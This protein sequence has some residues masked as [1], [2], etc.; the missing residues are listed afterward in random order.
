MVFPRALTILHLTYHFCSCSLNKIDH[1]HI[2]ISQPIKTGN[3]MDNK[4]KI[5]K[6]STS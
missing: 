2:L 5:Q 6:V 1:M 3:A 4:I